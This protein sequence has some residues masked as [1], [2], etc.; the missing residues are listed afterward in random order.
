MNLCLRIGLLQVYLCLLLSL[1]KVLVKVLPSP[2][3]KVIFELY[4]KNL[5]QYVYKQVTFWHRSFTFKF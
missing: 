3:L 2:V 5:L 4:Q 1:V